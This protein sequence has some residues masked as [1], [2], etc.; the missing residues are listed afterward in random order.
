MRGILSTLA[1]LL[2]V[3][4]ACAAPKRAITLICNGA[5]QTHD[6]SD[7]NSAQDVEKPIK[8]LG[9]IVDLAARKVMGVEVAGKITDV[10]AASISFKDDPES[11]GRPVTSGN[12]DRVGGSVTAQVQV[13]DAQDK[14]IDHRSYKLLCKPAKRMF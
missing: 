10:N 1:M 6:A 13:K 9:I 2:I 7:A 3:S 11:G 14:I 12:I 5:L 8:N 4:T